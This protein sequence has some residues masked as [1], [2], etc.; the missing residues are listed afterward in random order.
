MI[1]EM[2]KA[3]SPTKLNS[4][5]QGGGIWLKQNALKIRDFRDVWI[6]ALGAGGR[7]FKSPRPDQFQLPHLALLSTAADHARVELSLRRNS[8]AVTQIT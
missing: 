6:T 2:R 1:L 3:E 8:T 5:Q 7:A 4:F